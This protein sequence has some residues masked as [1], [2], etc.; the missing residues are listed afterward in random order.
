M[1]GWRNALFSA[2]A[3]VGASLFFSPA[4][5]TSRPET[6]APPRLTLNLNPH[7]LF[8]SGD[9]PDAHSDSVSDKK[10]IAV[11]L[12]H[13]NAI[14]PHRDID[15]QQFRNVSWYRRHLRLSTEYRNKRFILNFQGAAQVTEV[16]INGTS[17]GMHRGAYTPFSFDISELL[18]F[19][20]DNMIAVRVDSRKHKEIPP[21]G[22][23]LDYMLFGGL[24]RDVSLV[25][26]DPLHI[27]W[28]F[29]SRSTE[30]PACATVRCRINN[31]YPAGKH[32]LVKTLILDSAGVM[33]AHGSDTITIG[34]DSSGELTITT[35]RI[36]GLREWDTDHPCRYTIS[37]RIMLDSTV[38]D[39]YSVITGFR[40]ILFSSDDGKFYLNGK[41]L[42]LS[43]LNRHET[44]PFIGRAAA[45]RLQASDADRLKY[46]LGCNIV[47]CSHYPQDPEFLDRCDEI[48]LLVIEEIPGWIHVGDTAWQRNALT[49]VE[50]MVVRDRNHPSIISY[51][52]RI[53]ESYDFHDFYQKTNQLARS[54]DPTRPT[55]GVRLKDRG[56]P[57]EFMEDIWTENFTIP[58]GKP[59]RLPWLI[60]ESFGVGCQVHAWDDEENLI[61]K[62]LRFAEFIDSVNMNP[63]IAGQIGWCA[64][65]YNSSN[66]T[67]DGTVCYYG[68]S[69]MYRIP[70]H[71]GI[72]LRSQNDPTMAGPMVEILH[73]WRKKLSPN[74]VWVAGNC[75]RVELFI[76]GTSLGQKKPDQYQ[77]LRYPLTV[78]KNVAFSPGEIKA[79]G[80]I[81]DSVAA[82]TIRITPGPVVAL[83]IIP[84]D[85]M[86]VA[87]GDMTRIVVLAV[88]RH[89]QTV[90]QANNVV[91]L[92]VAG[93]ADFIGQSLIALEDGKTA[94]FV[95]SRSDETGVALCSAEAVGLAVVGATIKISTDPLSALRRK[96]VGK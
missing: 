40:S 76:N 50:E 66:R 78:W 18:R 13:C 29:A 79:V 65:D 58:R 72:F 91:A 47:R 51:G 54:L 46:D 63:F 45:N 84:D 19:R 12:P 31:N 48:G 96:I 10:F 94:F 70:K 68:A 55:H 1:F 11:C 8:F 37:T 38:V 28:L 32:C 35:S 69:D 21:E 90:P 83:K 4:S 80:Y 52:V 85:T 33:V 6:I 93:A 64:F 74:D 56:I 17:A 95:K 7:W 20:A 82:T 41:P 89:G 5:A 25:I 88:D 42:R 67:A 77:F 53:N 16:F 9:L 27:E 61:Q 2:A 75:K 36:T 39:E 59:D 43:G 86:I 44:Y 26:T 87:G 81:G 15:M 60:P 92:S 73:T 14:V 71:S 34:P 62:M 22:A 57:A 30:N 49:N 24:A 3:L 23:A